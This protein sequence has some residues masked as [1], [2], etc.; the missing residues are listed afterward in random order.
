M[1]KNSLYLKNHF[2]LYLSESAHNGETSL[3]VKAY[4][5]KDRYL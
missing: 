1:D 5:G 2:L 3:E 4:N